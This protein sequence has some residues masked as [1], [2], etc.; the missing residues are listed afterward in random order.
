MLDEFGDRLNQKDREFLTEMG[1]ELTTV[2]NEIFVV[3][4][5]FELGEGYAPSASDLLV[6]I[7][8]GYPATGMDM[9]WT[10]TMVRLTS[11]G[12]EPNRA[13]VY[14]PL[15]GEQWQR[16]SRHIT[17]RSG[18]DNVRTFMRAVRSDLDGAR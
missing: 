13:N 16:W 1:A 6:K 12:S 15:L 10:R 14:E 11:T 3:F 17:W 18:I 9:Y 4:K 5:G 7:P 8:T 2:G